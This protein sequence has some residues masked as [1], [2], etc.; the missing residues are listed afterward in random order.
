MS[1]KF[2]IADRNEQAVLRTQIF[3]HQLAGNTTAADQVLTDE[4]QPVTAGQVGVHRDKDD[5]FRAAR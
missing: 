3:R 4:A 2:R 1:V 5:P